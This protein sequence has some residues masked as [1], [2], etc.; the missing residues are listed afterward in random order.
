MTTLQPVHIA[1][2]RSLWLQEALAQEEEGTAATPPLRGGAM[3][4]VAIVGGGYTGLWTA[5][6]IK[7]LD[8]TVDVMILEADICGGGASGRNGGL[9]LGW[10]A[11]L[12]YLIAVCGEEEGVRL[13][14]AATAAVDEI[15]AFCDRHGIQAHYR[16][17]GLLNVAT[18]PMHLRDWSQQIA[19]LER[20]GIHDAERV[21]GPDEAAARGGSPSYLGGV[22][23]Q[24][25]A[26]MQPALLA[27]GMRRV[28]LEQGIRIHE[29]TPVIEL[30]NERVPTLRTPEGVVIAKKVV[31]ATNAWAAGLQE[32]RRSIVVLSSDMVA[33]APAPERVAATG[34]TGGEAITDARLMV[35]YHQVTHDGR[36]AIGRGSG[37]LAYLGQ[38]TPTFNESHRRSLVVERGLRRFYPTLGDIPVTH[39]W[40]GAVDRSRTNTLVFGA[41]GGN[42]NVR[43]GVGYSGTGVAPSVI[44]GRILASSVLERDD[45]WSRT[46]LNQGPAVLFPPEPARFFGGLLVRE[47]TRIKEENE[48]RVEPTPTPV[49]ALA[50]LATARTPKRRA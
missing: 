43:Y 41:L 15:G 20:Y 4:D 21:L 2:T 40:A 46:R 25:A 28:A 8:P 50:S 24:D 11:K 49:K 17:G 34:W 14:K 9:V 42:P 30:Q 22:F 1:K 44:G 19:F 33:T 10:Y 6:R 45:E 29:Q 18:T 47:A 48:E 37:A 13:A 38:V 27:R 23:E 26:T 16:K 39:R 3:T 36:I 5:L 32:L 31:L 7:E 12:K 35:H